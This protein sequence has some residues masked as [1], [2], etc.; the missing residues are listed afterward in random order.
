AVN[1]NLTE[2]RRL[3]EGLHYREAEEKL[4]LARHDAALTDAERL[5]AYELL[6][7]ALI[8]QTRVAEGE[9]VFAELLVLVPNAPAPHDTSPKVE[10]AF[11]RTKRRMYPPDFVKLTQRAAPAGEVQV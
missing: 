7:Q 4:R 1:P 11:A 6:A 8:A 9:D 10:E 2:G 5:E 3:Y